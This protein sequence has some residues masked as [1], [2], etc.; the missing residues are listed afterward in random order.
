MKI[1][2]SLNLGSEMRDFPPLVAFIA[3]APDVAVAGTITIS[4][5]R[6]SKP[7]VRYHGNVAASIWFIVRGCVPLGRYAVLSKQA[8]EG[9]LHERDQ[10]PALWPDV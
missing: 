6:G 9:E 5:T 10:V 1:R 3:T 2:H 7:H 8:S 4:A